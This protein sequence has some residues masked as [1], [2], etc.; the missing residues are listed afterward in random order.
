MS[1]DNMNRLLKIKLL[2]AM[3][4][5][6]AFSSIG[7]S[8]VVSP[9]VAFAQ[10]SDVS[11]LSKIEKLYQ[12][13]GAKERI[14]GT[15]NIGIITFGTEI[16]GTL[17]KQLIEVK[18]PPA[19]ASEIAEKAAEQYK[20]K[21]REKI[22]PLV[23]ESV[24]TYSVST[25]SH[26]SEQD[27]DR[28]IEFYSSSAIQDFQSKA[29]DISEYIVQNVLSET[30]DYLTLIQSDSEQGKPMRPYKPKDYSSQTAGVPPRR[31]EMIKAVVSA[32]KVGQSLA[33]LYEEPLKAVSDGA[34]TEALKKQFLAA[35]GSMHFPTLCEQLAVIAYEK[36]IPDQQLAEIHDYLTDANL[37]KVRD[38]QSAAESEIMDT[39][40][41]KYTKISSATY[42][43]IL[44]ELIPQGVPPA[45]AAGKAPVKAQ[46]RVPA[47]VPA[48][49]K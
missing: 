37:T 8:F 22:V 46:A 34:P 43:S 18:C 3:C 29:K 1:K 9:S 20:A 36:N 23:R 25:D 32:S 6:L 48:K 7:S 42:E 4:F 47:K 17:R 16:N 39:V 2:R 38:Q 26:L 24:I 12:I 27:V 49:K 15:L 11:K 5:T 10:S 40:G 33:T 35:M 19:K 14:D 13:S 30:K 45:R 41:E 21:M 28:L 31:L 44:K